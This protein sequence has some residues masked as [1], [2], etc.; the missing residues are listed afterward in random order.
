MGIRC[1]LLPGWLCVVRVYVCQVAAG[2]IAEKWLSERF[3]VSIVA[4]MFE[5]ILFHVLLTPFLRTK[6]AMLPY[7]LPF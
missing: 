5:C 1:C 2:A 7:S 4:F 3:G 6:T